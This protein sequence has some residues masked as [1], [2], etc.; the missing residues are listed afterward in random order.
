MRETAVGSQVLEESIATTRR[1]FE[2][3]E[4]YLL[5]VEEV[6]DVRP[7]AADDY[8]MET[9]QR[10]TPRD[11]PKSQAYERNGRVLWREDLQRP[12]VG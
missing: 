8:E 2:L 5:L 7:I 6:P 9:R 11:Y 10:A 4:V 3:G 12:E 1:G